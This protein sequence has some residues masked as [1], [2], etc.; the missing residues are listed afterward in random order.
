MDKN[1]QNVYRKKQCN[2]QQ[3]PQIEGNANNSS[4]QR[5]M[6]QA[7]KPQ[8]D[9]P[10]GLSKTT[11]ESVTA[12]ILDFQSISQ[13]LIDYKFPLASFHHEHYFTFEKKNM[14]F[15]SPWK[16]FGMH[17]NTQVCSNFNKLIDMSYPESLLC[18]SQGFPLDR[19]SPYQK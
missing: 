15:I 10:A 19:F 17:I 12:I 16:A 6:V 4:S 9:V 1:L 3:S 7:F 14:Q 2:Y 8:T 11:Q 18:F 5:L 13:H